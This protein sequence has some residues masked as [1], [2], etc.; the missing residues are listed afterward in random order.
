MITTTAKFKKPD[1]SNHR[2]NFEKTAGND[3]VDPGWNEGFLS[4]GRPYR[5]ECWC[6]D[7]VTSL[8][9]FFSTAG[10]ENI[11]N[12]Q[13]A[14]M[15]MSE[16]LLKFLSDRRFVAAAPFTDASGNDMWSVNVVVGDEETVFVSDH[17]PLRSYA[18]PAP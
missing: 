1:R 6:Q 9:F 5:V 14:D 15:L 2:P 8:T 16:G 17:V 10:L 11:S 3:V 13:F 4:D 12:S 7:Q 18:R